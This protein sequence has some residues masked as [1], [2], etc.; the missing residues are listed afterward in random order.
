MQPPGFP[1]NDEAAPLP[2]DS[3]PTED[4][5]SPAPAEDPSVRH[6]QESSS[7][8]M[9][10]T[11]QDGSDDPGSPKSDESG[12]ASPGSPSGGDDILEE[13][14]AKWRARKEAK[15]Q[16]KPRE[17]ASAYLTGQKN[18]LMASRSAGQTSEGGSQSIGDLGLVESRLPPTVFRS[19]SLS[20]AVTHWSP[21]ENFSH[22]SQTSVEEQSPLGSLVGQFSQEL[23]VSP[24]VRQWT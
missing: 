9:L 21:P 24:S 6:A 15:L 22:R 8:V 11:A 3:L 12:A 17:S 19:H 2:S 5:L 23:D 4:M 7:S 20:E 10:P 16:K 18:R 1:E 14:W 13:K